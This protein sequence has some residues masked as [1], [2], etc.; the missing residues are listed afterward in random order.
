MDTPRLLDCL[1]ADYELLRGAATTADSTAPVPSCPGWT[2]RDLVSHVGQ[3]YL[4]KVAA[5]NTG[6]WPDP[7][8]TE[9]M[10]Q[11]APMALLTRG[12]TELTAEF[13]RHAPEDE[14][15]TWYEPD[16]TV[17]FW[18]RRMAQETVIHRMDAQLAAG[19]A[20]TEAPDDLAVD[21]IDEVLRCFLAYAV[22][23]WPADFAKVE[24][25]DGPGTIVVTAGQQT[26]GQHSWT[27]RTEQDK[28]TV[29]DGAAESPQVTV[30]ASPDGMLRWLWGRADDQAVASTG[31]PAW[32][33]YL[34][35]LLV[36]ST[37]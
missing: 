35:Q 32:A 25:P 19:V 10:I 11:E 14:A 13:S 33:A 6:Q 34:R 21:G 22:A 20:V 16:Q 4:H 30:S 2:M 27:L 26:A 7:W 28:V 23:N 29:S 3:V 1:A 9:A 17:G 36:E 37:Q 31:D 5:M 24:R 8:P 18:I 15:L 12:Y